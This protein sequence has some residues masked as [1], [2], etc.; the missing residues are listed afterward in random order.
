MDAYPQRIG[1]ALVLICS[2]RG[3]IG[4]GISFGSISFVE[5]AGYK[6]ALNIC[7]GILAALMGMGV[8]VYVFGAKIRAITQK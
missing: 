4:F 7:A 2:L 6:G 8:V 3:F 1:A 5:K